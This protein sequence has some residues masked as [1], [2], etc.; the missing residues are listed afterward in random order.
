MEVTLINVATSLV[1]IFTIAWMWKALNWIW[2]KPKILERC[3]TKQG[4]RGQPYKVLFGDTKKIAQMVKETTSK[5]M[6]HF[7]NHYTPRIFPFHHQTM[8]NYGMF[9]Y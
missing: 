6:E 5:P 3:L 8:E 1:C 7:S 2:L 4:F 9:Y